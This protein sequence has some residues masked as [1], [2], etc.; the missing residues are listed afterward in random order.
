MTEVL[1]TIIYFNRKYFL[2][3]NNMKTYKSKKYLTVL[4]KVFEYLHEDRESSKR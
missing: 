1:L 3:G 2:G 4:N